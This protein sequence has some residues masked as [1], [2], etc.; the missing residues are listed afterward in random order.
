MSYFLTN[1]SIEELLE[2]S[3]REYGNIYLILIAILSP[4][5]NISVFG[6]ALR[7]FF[8]KKMHLCK[9]IDLKWTRDVIIF[10]RIPT[11]MLDMVSL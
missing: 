4:D 11:R 9:D 3:Y 8:S 6:G 10:H 7:Y 5:K 1:T 2:Y